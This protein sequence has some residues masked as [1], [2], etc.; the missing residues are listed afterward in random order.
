[1]SAQLPI[2]TPA[3]VRRA[4][5][6]LIRADSRAFAAVLL[7]NSAAAGAGLV[8]PWLLGRIIDEVRAG[9]G[10]GAVDRLGLV[11]VV[12]AVAQL[13]LARW[14]RYVG[15]R[16]GER[17]LARVREEFVDRALALPA[18]VVERAGPAI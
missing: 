3:D 13:L 18:S 17:T 8:A 4:A 11:I 2:A 16:F 14:A 5:V 6:R 9:A 12:C 10:V 1:M 15:Y 7:L